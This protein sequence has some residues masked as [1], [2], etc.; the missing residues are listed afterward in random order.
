[1]L[2]IRKTKNKSYTNITYKKLIFQGLTQ[3]Y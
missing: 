3:Y 2:R 1:M